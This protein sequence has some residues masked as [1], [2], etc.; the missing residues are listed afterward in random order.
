M[1]K[2]AEAEI[3]RWL[4][5]GGL[6]VTASDRAART[7]RLA[8]HRR[9][10]AEGQ[11]A[12]PAPSILDWTSFTHATW[13]ER[14]LDGR[15]ILNAVQ[16]QALWT[17]IVRS[18]EQL[19]TILPGPIHR[20]AQMAMQA[21]ELLCSYAPHSLQAAARTAWDQDAGAFSGWLAAFDEV[22]RDGNLLSPV[23]VPL[24]L[25]ASLKADQTNRPPLLAAGFD[26][27]LP[28]QR[29]LLDAWGTWQEATPDEP[30][31]EIRFYTAADSQ[32][33]LEACALWCNRQLAANPHARLLVISQQISACRGEIE[34]AFLRLSAPGAEPRFEFSLGIPL[35]QVELARAAHLLLRWLSGPLQEHEVDWL[36]STRLAAPDP[37][38]TAAL[39]AYMRTLRRRGLARTEWTP[40]AFASHRHVYEVFPDAWLQ[41]MTA[42]RRR[43]DFEARRQSPLDWAGLVPQL[44][45]DAGWPGERRLSSAEFQAY[46][47]WEQA[48]DTCGSLGFDG[49]RMGWNEFL[50]ALKRVLDETL[51]APESSDAPIQIAGPAESAG[52]TADAIWFLGADEDT[53]PAAASMHPLLPTQVQREAGMPHATPRQDWEFAG[54]VTKRLLAAAPVVHFSVAGQK[55]STE[56]RPSRLIAQ[57]AG[58]PQALPGEWAPPPIQPDLTECIEDFSQIPFPLE[59]VKGGSSVLSSQSQC[60]FKAFATARLGAQAWDAAEAGLTAAQRGQLLHS[61]LHAVWGGPPNGL[62][63]L[64]ELLAVHDRETFVA[65][66]V[67]KVLQENM[68]GG[69]RQRMP[70]RYLELEE[71]RLTRLVTEWLEFEAT[72]IPFTVA[73][74]EAKRNI[75]LA[76]VTLGL[77]LDRIDR[78][79][80]GS[81]LVIDYKTGDVSPKD[82]ELPRPDDVQLPLYAGFALPSGEELGGLVFAKVRT[83]ERTFAGHM[84]DAVNTL[85]PNLSKGTALVKDALTAEKLID[86]REYIEQLARDFLAGRAEVDPREYPK[87]CQHC[88]LQTLCRIQELRARQESEDENEEGDDE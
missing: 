7:L 42:A 15:M 47:R 49:L 50:S 2:L 23:R 64:D 1:G 3:D 69:V 21:H 67:H 87:T 38:E 78:L 4:S 35:S 25:I 46:R 16:E 44:L 81:M 68:P 58:T 53:W 10:R 22:C 80:D 41:R 70:K 57:L 29:T 39:Q 52:L 85:L 88:G 32:T 56:T 30:A 13:E 45:Q 24:A 75:E 14:T 6:V 37:K 63:N 55:E 74:T 18:K 54:A 36:L 11:L 12:W 48:L 26:R 31:Q 82:W 43:T 40:E 51:Y 27:L 17:D 83:G 72:R 20:L 77:R 8:F 84:G 73:E 62:R 61:V 33:E 76:G 34:R 65:G 60:P 9:R 71:Q 28:V 5:G 19:A 66:H 86:W 59:T 79:I